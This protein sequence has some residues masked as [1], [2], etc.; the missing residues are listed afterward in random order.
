MLWGRFDH[1]LFLEGFRSWSVRLMLPSWR[2]I[3]VAEVSAHA[4]RAFYVLLGDVHQVLHC[5]GDCAGSVLEIGHHLH[6]V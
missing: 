3:G 4:V 1:D 2:G 6:E 5:L